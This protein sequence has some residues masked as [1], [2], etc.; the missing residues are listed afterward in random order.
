M[1]SLAR[2]PGS[3]MITR[4]ETTAR[5]GWTMPDQLRNFVDGQSVAAEDGRTTAVVDPS[6]GETYAEAPL[7]GAAD[8]DRACRA[9]ESAF[10]QWRD[11]TPSE[12]SL[13]LWKLAEAIESRAED[14]IAAEGRNTG[15][16]LA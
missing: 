16:P 7:S 2:P 11:T 12:R 8:V 13:L 1:D 9:A 4:F 15:K 6:T 3:A 5:G 14:F 10:A